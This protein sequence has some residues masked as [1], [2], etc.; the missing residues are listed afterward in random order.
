LTACEVEPYNGY[1]GIYGNYSI[2]ATVVIMIII[3]ETDIVDN[4]TFSVLANAE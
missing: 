4:V 1:D 3:S 2:I